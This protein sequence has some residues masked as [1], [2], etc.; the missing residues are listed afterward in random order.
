MSQLDPPRERH[1][2]MNSHINGDESAWTF[3][4][5]KTNTGSTKIWEDQQKRVVDLRELSRLAGQRTDAV[6]EV[7]KAMNDYCD[8]EDQHH[9]GGKTMQVSERSL[10]SF[11]LLRVQE[12]QA[13]CNF[14]DTRLISEETEILMETMIPVASPGRLSQ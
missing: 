7:T 10:G 9:C 13:P 4:A 3:D 12:L 11:S 8:H 6:E 1:S 14:A 5:R 2:I